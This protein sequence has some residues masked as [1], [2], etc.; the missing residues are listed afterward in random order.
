MA[1]STSSPFALYKFTSNGDD[2][3]TI[4]DEDAIGFD[5]G[6]NEQSTIGIT[7]FKVGVPQ[8]RTDVPNVGVR[9]T[10]KPPTSLVAVPIQFDFYVNEKLADQP[11]PIA[12]LLKFSLEN[13]DVRGTFKGRFGLRNDSLSSFPEIVPT[14]TEGIVFANLEFDDEITWSQGQT[15]TVFLEYIGTYADFI[16]RLNTIINA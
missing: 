1:D 5:Y 2:E 9:S 13:Q 11:K 4:P 7:A 10:S 8:R 15:G 16:T 6:V 14:A 12:K 3:A